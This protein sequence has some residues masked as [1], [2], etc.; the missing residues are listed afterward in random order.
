MSWER[1]RPLTIGVPRR[2]HE[3]FVSELYDPSD[4][5]QFYRPIGGGIEFG[6]Y[7]TDALVRE[8]QEELDIKV[9]VSD[10]LGT[11]ENVFTF[12]DSPG[13]E[14]VL[15][16]EIAVPDVLYKAHGEVVDTVRVDETDPELF[17]ELPVTESYW[18]L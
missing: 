10:Y 2:E 16:Y 5:K 14:V 8:F 9:K 13:H 3:I 18:W 1:I 7:S 11:I 15:V 12:D 17:D 6:E 4:D